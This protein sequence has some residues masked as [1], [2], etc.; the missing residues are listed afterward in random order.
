MRT[1]STNYSGRLVD[2]LVFQ[3]T[4]PSGKKRIEMT[5]GEGGLLTTGIQKVAQTF[6]TILLTDTGTV[7]DQPDYG[8]DFVRSIQNGIAHTE[9]GLKSSFSLAVAEVKRIMSTA[10]LNNNLPEDE[11]LEDAELL[12]YELDKATGK[13]GI[14]VGIVAVAGPGTTIYIPVSVPIQ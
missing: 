3:N 10:A 5:F 6:T 7:Y 13:I 14:T 9:D 11:Q 1:T 2:M 4:N 12:D 8:T